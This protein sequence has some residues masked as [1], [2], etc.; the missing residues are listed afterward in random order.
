LLRFIQLKV[1]VCFELKIDQI[2]GKLIRF[3]L[4]A[5]HK[6][7]WVEELIVEVSQLTG[8]EQK[9]NGASKRVEKIHLSKIIKKWDPTAYS[10]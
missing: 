8:L 2:R 10:I 6:D 7:S 5:S 1:A 3:F 9:F 4:P